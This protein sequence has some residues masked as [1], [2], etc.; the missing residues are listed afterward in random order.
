MRVLITAL[1][2]LLAGCTAPMSADSPKADLVMKSGTDGRLAS[3]GEEGRRRAPWIELAKDPASFRSLWDR[4]VPGDGAKAAHEIDFSKEMAVF[5][6]LGPQQTGGYAIEPW[7][8]KVDGAVV[9]VQAK[10]IQP[11]KPDDYAIQVITAP[12]AVVRA[13]AI[14]FDRVEWIDADGRVLATRTAE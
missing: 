8:V 6:L 13:P 1:A 11:M 4:F 3:S 10:L 5:L 7:N 14:A 12:Y 2:L 9:K